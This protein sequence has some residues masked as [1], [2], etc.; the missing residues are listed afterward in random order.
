MTRLFVLALCVLLPTSFTFA[1]DPPAVP[2]VLEEI[3]AET[4]L[5]TVRGG[6]TGRGASPGRFFQLVHVLIDDA[7]L[8]QLE[9]GAEDEHV[10][11]RLA[12]LYALA[13]RDAERALPLLEAR[14][15]SEVVV[16]F[17]PAGCGVSETTEAE[18]AR[19]FLD[20]A[21]CLEVGAPPR[22]LR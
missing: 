1:Q 20:D 16:R 2:A 15:E 7:E 12:C 19:A 22:P 11:V 5:M 6:A 18:V 9:E 10:I 8:E 4:P 13:H 17:M 14:L 21:N 3:R